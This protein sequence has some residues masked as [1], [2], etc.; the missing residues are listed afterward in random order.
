MATMALGLVSTLII[1][2]P[3]T[4]LALGGPRAPCVVDGAI[5][6]DRPIFGLNS[7]TAPSTTHG[8]RG[9]RKPSSSQESRFIDQTQGS[10]PHI[11]G[12]CVK[13]S[14]RGRC[15]DR[16]ASRPSRTVR[17]GRRPRRFE[18]PPVSSN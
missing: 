4:C 5:G 13:L 12:A 2:G 14:P 16:I 10:K 3:S 15:T 8:P 7:C 9:R 17:L 6:S 1:A 18:S 11:D